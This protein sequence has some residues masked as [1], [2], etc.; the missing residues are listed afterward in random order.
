M[1]YISNMCQNLVNRWLMYVKKGSLETVYEFGCAYLD[2]N[3]TVLMAFLQT[4]GFINF[5]T[6]K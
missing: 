6:K 4:K 3:S 1:L 2:K 5:N